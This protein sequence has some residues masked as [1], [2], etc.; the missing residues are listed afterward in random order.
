MFGAPNCQASDVVQTRS[1]PLSQPEVVKEPVSAATKYN[2]GFPDM[3]MHRGHNAEEA[4]LMH[5]VCVP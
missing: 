5:E 4:G 2:G 1:Q 3:Y